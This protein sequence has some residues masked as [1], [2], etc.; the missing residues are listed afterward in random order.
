MDAEPR[1]REIAQTQVVVHYGRAGDHDYPNQHR[2]LLRRID[3]SSWLVLTPDMKQAVEDLGTFKYT[4][5]RRDVLFPEY[6]IEARLY[7]HDP[8]VAGVL[9]QQIRDAR[10]EAHIQG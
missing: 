6:N 8:I 9:R 1:C 4:V 10:E 2:I 5:I 7:Y 3:E